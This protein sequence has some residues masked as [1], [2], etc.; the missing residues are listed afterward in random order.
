MQNSCVNPSDKR[1]INIEQN[2]L[3]LVLIQSDSS[4]E[5]T[6]LIEVREILSHYRLPL[7]A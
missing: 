7:D 1:S 5:N 3:K 4:T 6:F 2:T